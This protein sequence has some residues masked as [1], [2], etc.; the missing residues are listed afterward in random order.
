MQDKS[1]RKTSNLHY[2][3]RSSRAAAE[4]S[5]TLAPSSPLTPGPSGHL[6][7]AP[8]PGQG[9]IPQHALLQAANLNIEELQASLY[10]ISEPG[11]IIASGQESGI[12][13]SSSSSLH[14]VELEDEEFFE[15]VYEEHPEDSDT[16]PNPDS[17]QQAGYLDPM[18]TA[19]KGKLDALKNDITIKTQTIQTYL[20]KDP[21]TNSSKCQANL[22]LDHLHNMM[23]EHKEMAATYLTKLPRRAGRQS[24]LAST[25]TWPPSRSPSEIWRRISPR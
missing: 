18:A 3:R 17:S 20:A 1:D 14:E 22:H 25:P 15:D 7:T 4:D 24:R 21:A 2:P 10:D 9:D 5:T 8:T 12:E 23:A 16:E 11:N 19:L 6:V 13:E